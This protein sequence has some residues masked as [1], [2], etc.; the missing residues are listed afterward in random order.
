MAIDVKALGAKAKAAG[1]DQTQAQVGGGDYTPP[2]E[3][4]VRLRFVTYAE[5]GKHEKMFKGTKKIKPRVMMG[6][7]LSGPNHPPIE[8]D[9]KKIPQRITFEEGLSQF[10]KAH[11]FK[12]FNRMN[13]KG[14]A[15]HMVELLGDG[16]KGEVVHRK[17]AKAGEDKGDKIKWTGVA[18]ELFKKDFGYT[19][20]S[21]TFQPVDPESGDPV[22]PVKTMDIAPVLGDI[23]A[24]LWDVADMEQWQSLFIDG[25]YEDRKDAAGKVTQAGKSKNLIQARIMQAKN[26]S[27][28]PIANLL[29]QA[30]VTL[31]IPD[32][33]N[34][35]DR[36]DDDGDSAP[37][38]SAQAANPPA[39][40]RPMPEGNA[41]TDAL[42]GIVG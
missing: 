14:A 9:G 25:K 3:G 10:D 41:A 34:P 7:E 39:D 13:W 35:T 38:S 40:P 21:P 4:P 37:A 15:T 27:G 24:F 42:A 5:I 8:V 29:K 17:Y 31:S 26:F 23:K 22:G 32:V 2:A 20:A 18:A 36:D 6:F 19:I 28:S 33:D 16:Y 1:A 12:L 30:G 11:F